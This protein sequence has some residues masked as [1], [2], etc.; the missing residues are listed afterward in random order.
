[1]AVVA[2]GVVLEARVVDGWGTLVDEVTMAPVA[3]LG[4]TG[5]VV[6]GFSKKG[7]RWRAPVVFRVS[8]LD[9][10]DRLAVE[11]EDFFGSIAN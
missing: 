7:A 9:W 2:L 6:V 1:M 10:F 11:S 5:V 3:T 4:Q 8:K